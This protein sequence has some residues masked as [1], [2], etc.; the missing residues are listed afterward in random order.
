MT[1]KRIQFNNVIQ[2][3]LPSYVREEFP[4]VAEFLKQ[5]YF[6]QEFQGSAADLVQ[7]VD[8]YLKLDNI[9]SNT[10]STALSVDI[11]FFDETISVVSTVGFPDSYGLLQVDDEVI[12]YTNKTST[13]FTGC[14]RGFSGVTSYNDQ[15]KPDELV[16]KSTE[17]A[18]HKKDTKVINLSSL[19]LKEFF[20][21][22]KYQ[23]TPGFENREFY[24]G[25]DKY[26]FLKQSKD[27]YST[28]GT[29]LSFKILFKVL[30]GED[31]KIIKPQDYLS[32]PSDSQ[33]EITNDLV[34]ESITGD[35]YELERSTLRQDSYDNIP[36]GYASISRV[37]KIFTKSDKTYYKLSFDAGYNRD[38]GVDGSLYGNFSI[39]PKT[40]IIGGILS[41]ENT[42]D[43]DSTV[44]FPLQGNLSVTYNDGTSGVVSYTSKSLNQFFGC[45][46]ITKPI[47][48]GTDIWLDV[49]AYGLSNKNTNT[50]IKVRI[51]SV[52]NN[53][54]IADDAY[55]YSAGDTGIIKTLGVN[56]QDEIVSNNWIFNISSGV[57]VLSLSLVDNTA[58]TYRLTTKISHNLKV[59]DS[60]KLLSNDGTSAISSVTNV[61]SASVIEVSGQ[62]ILDLTRLYS[63]QRNLL[64]VNSQKYSNL[65]NQITDVQN[66]YKIEDKTLVASSSLPSYNNQPLN[67]FDRSVVFSGTFSGDTFTITSGE[68]HGFYTGDSVYYTP[69]QGSLFVEGLYFIKR[70]NQSSVKI[71]KSRANIYNSIFINLPDSITVSNSKFE[72]YEFYSKK[73]E[74]QKI[75]REIN[76]P[77]NDGKEYQT[78]PGPVGILINGVEVLNYKSKDKIFYGPIENID[79]VNSGS[80][81]DIINPPSLVITD[82]VGSGA[83]GYCSV[84]GS[85][86]EIRIIDPGFDYLEVPK[87]NIT[88]GNGIGAKASASMKLIDH[89]VSFNSES[90]SAFVSVS[91]NTIG[92][93]TF[94]KFRSAEKVVYRTNA[95]KAVGGITTNSTYYVSVQDSYTIKLHKTFSDSLV[96]VNTIALTS[97]GIGNHAL[98]AYNKKSVIS[99]INIESA[100]SD[101]Q[102][103]KRTTT[104][105]GISTSLGNITIKNHDYQSGEIV[106]YST[107]G[108]V[109][110][111]LS[112]NTNYYVTKVDEDRFKLSTV[113][114][115]TDN[116]DFYYKTQQYIDLTSTGSGIHNFNY[117]QISVEVVGSIGVS[118]IFKAKVQ[119][120][121]RGEITSVHLENNGVGYGSS[122]I[123]NFSRDANVTLNSGSDAQLIPIINAGKIVEV[124]VNNPGKD[125]NSPPNLSILTNGSGI[126]A[127]LTPVLENGQ[128]KSI[129]IVESGA[130]YDQNNISI[131]V[132]SA[133][134][135]ADLKS[136][137]KSWTINHFTRYLSKVTTDDGFV[138]YNPNS[139]YGL[140]YSHLYVPRKLRENVYAKETG[141]KILYGKPDLIK[142]NGVE[143]N[144]TS[145]SPI[146]GWAYDGNPIYGPY[147]FANKDGGLI[148]RMKSG[149]IL[150]Q[151]L[152]R[153]PFSSGFFV[154]DFKYK[155]I[156]DDS[157]LDEYNGRFCI[158]P[159]FPNGTYAYFAT[160]DNTSSNSFG[161]YRLPIFPYIVG[162]KFKSAPNEFNYK[163][164]S[165][166]DDIDLNQTKWSRNTT[167]Y[168]L[169]KNNASYAYLSLPNILD[170]TTDVKYASPGS[171][172]NIGIVTGGLNYK[173][174]DKVLFDEQETGGFGFASRVSRI[175]GKSVNSISV[176]N[177]TINGAEIYSLEG[178]KNLFFI[179]SNSP[180]SLLN[181]DIV[182]I[183]GIN[184]TS[185]LI[186]GSYTIGISTNTLSVSI[187]S[188]I[189]SVTV[190]GIVTYIS[191]SGDLSNVKEND[192][193]RIETEKLKV[194]NVDKDS[195]RIRVL[196]S[197]EGTVGSAHSYTDVLYE[198]PRRFSINVGNTTS[199]GYKLNREIYFDPKESLG[200]GT[201]SGVGIGSTLSFSNPGV[202]V[203]QIFI[204]T[205]TIYIPNHNLETGDSLVYS[206][207][208]GNAISI[209][210]TGAS[211]VLL[212]D[213]STVY[214]AKITND[215]IGISTVKVG[216]GT[217][218][219]FVG[220]ATTTSTMGTLYFTGIGT[221]TY[222]SFKTN[223]PKLTCKVSKN[224]VTVSTA[225]THGL[226]NNDNVFVSV[227]PGLSTT[228]IIKYNDYNRKV[229]A[230]SRSFVSGDIDI[231]SNSIS[232][233]NHNFDNGQKVVYNATS[234]SGGLIN[235]KIYY[236]VVFDSNTVKLSNSY[237]S[238]VG[239]NPEIVDITTASSG[240]LSAVNPPIKVYKDSTV[241][242]DLSDSSLSYLNGS[243]QYSAFEFNF[244]LDSNYTQ[245]FNKSS[246]SKTFEV[247]RSGRIGIDTGASVTLSVTN[248][249]PQKLYYKLDPVYDSTLPLIKEEINVDSSVRANNEIQVVFSGYNGNHRITSIA[250]TSFTYNVEELPESAIYSSSS[251]ISYETT[252]QSAFGPVSKVD[253]TSKGQNYSSLPK[254]SKIVSSI[255]T[256]SIL[257]ASSKS[258][259]KVQKTKL[260][261]IGFDF[262][263]DFTVR[264]NLILPQILKIEP[265]NSIDYIGITSTGRG[266]ISA[267]KLVVL[268]GSTKQLL[269][270]VDIRYSLEDN[271]VTI[272]KNTYR[273]NDTTPTIIPTQNSN[274]VGIGSIFHNLANNNVTVTLSVGFSTLSSF[275]FAVNDKILIENISVGIN[276][277]GKGFNSENYNY[278][279]FTIT[280]VDA[281]IGG[282]GTVTYNLSDHLN[283][284]EVPGRYDPVNS[285]GR[286]IPEKYFPK[287]NVGLKPNN[288]FEN[289][290][291][292]YPNQMTSLGFVE[293]WNERTK[294]VRISSRE[295]IKEGNVLEGVSSKTQGRIFSAIKTEGFIDV[296][297]YSK[298]ENGW[299]TETGVLNNQ[300]QRIQDNFY[301]QNF[302]YSLKSKVPYD[303]WENSVGSLNHTSGFKKFS[304]Y[305][306]ESFG[307]SGISTDAVSL[308]DVTT[309]IDGFASLNCVYDF[310]LARENALNIGS[311]LISDEITFSSRILTDYFESV[312]NRVLSIDDIS[313]QFNSNP[314]TTRFSIVHRFLLTDARAQK[315]VTYVKDR[316][317]TS[318][319]QLMLFTLLHD[320]TVGYLNQ[321]GRVETVYD[322]G[323]FDFIVDGPEG[324][325]LFYPTKY[326]VNDY[327]VTT[328]SYNL[329][330]NFSGVGN[331]ILGNIV[332]LN[333]DTAYV[334]SGSTSIIDIDS[335][336]TS[337]KV[338]IEIS[339]DNGQYQF[340]ELN[341]VHDGTN[342]EMLDYGQ[343]TSHST[344]TFSSSGLGTYYP[345]FSGSNL[346]IDFIP[347]VGIAAS[348]ST[349]QIAIA[350]TSI[351]GVGTF[352]LKYARFEAVTTSIASTTSPSANI[353][354][355]YPDTYDA[356]YYIIQISDTTN[357]RHQLSEVILVDDEYDVYIT[358]FG[359]IET[360]SSLG[361]VGAIKTTNS[362]RLTFTPLPNI[363]AHVKV[364]FNSITNFDENNTSVQ[365]NNNTA[366]TDYSVYYGTERDVK[367]SFDLKHQ[368]NPIFQKYFD[369]SNPS[370]VSVASSVITINNHFFVTGENVTYS[371]GIPTATASPIGIALTYFGVGIGTTDKLP[372]SVY[373][374]KVDEN[375]IKLARS[376]EDALKIVP[377]A[378]NI[379]SVGIGS[380]HVFISTKQN[381]KSLVS[382]DNVI[383]SPIVSTSTTT[384]LSTN[385]LSVEDLVYLDSIKDIIT[386]DL[387][388]INDEIMK[389]DSVGVGSTN[390]IR[391]ARPWLGT[392]V[393]S[394]PAGS[395]I[396][397]L[398]GNY[399]IVKNKINFVEAPY[400]NI[401]L[402]TS[403]NSPSERD[404]AGITSSS[405]FHGRVFMRSGIIDSPNE[406]YYKNYIF[407]DISS[408]FNG[409]RKTF[410]LSS[411][412]SNI[413]DIFQDNAIIL[414]NDI[415]QQPG[416]TKNYNLSESVGVTSISFVGS[417]TSQVSDV[418]TSNLP[419]GG[420]I[421]SVGSTKGFGYQPLVSAGGSAIVSVAGTI[422][423][424]SIGN[425]GSG[426]RSAIETLSGILPVTVRVGVSTYSTGT[427]NVEFIGTATVSNGNIVSIAVTNPGI[428]YTSSNPPYVI[429]DAPLSY[430]DIPLIYNSSSLGI[431]TRATVDI[432]V[433]Q[434][435]GVIDFEIKNTGYR[436]KSGDILTVPVGGTIGIPTTPNSTLQ[437]FQITV[438]SVDK[439]KFSGWSLGELEVLDNIQELFDG[440]RIIFPLLYNGASISVYAKKG[441]LIDV[442]YVLLVFINDILQIPDEGY[443]F[444]GGSKIQF[445]EPPKPEDTCKILFYK[446]SGDNIDVIFRDIIDTVKIG[447]DLQLTYDSFVGQSPSLLE[448][449]RK[450]VD[451]LSIETVET[452]SYFGPGNTSNTSL[453]RPINW[454]RQTEDLIINEKEISKNREFY[455]PLI[456]PSTNIIQSVG[457]GSTI[458]YVENLRPFFNPSNE[459][460]VSLD[461]QN[462]VTLI[463]QDSKISATAS[464][465][466]SISG[467]I[468]SID[469]V[470]GGFG[471]NTAPKVTLQ[472]STGIGLSSSV[473]VSSITSGIVTS[474]SIVGVLT[475]YSISNPPLVLIDPPTADVE[476][477]S[478][479]SYSGDSGIIVGL[480]TTNIGAS[481]QI[482]LDLFIPSNSPNRIAS[483][484]GTATTLSSLSSGDF[485]VVSNSNVG[486]STTSII[487]KRLD[488]SNIGI[489]NE[490]LD[491]IYQVSSA[492]TV[493]TNVVGV[494]TTYIRRIFSPISGIGT[495]NFSSSS[496]NFDSNSYTFDNL[497]VNTL[498]SG[499]ISTSRYFGD[500]SWGKIILK[501]RVKDLEFNYYGNNGV[502]GITT[503][504]L[505][506]R[507]LP[508]KYSNYII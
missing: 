117:P 56:P 465:I 382:I 404:W 394:H 285:S 5:Y 222:H 62:G 259:G 131:I 114:I 196:R 353:I 363:D 253:I 191:V 433:G 350:N 198:H 291:V 486:I 90:K 140:Q 365:Y 279:L 139:K 297:P 349:V 417:A 167:P 33:Y 58:N 108:T 248:N 425:S 355:E 38:I 110:G 106:K 194:L 489:A 412:G 95:Q 252:S 156:N 282:I 124:L 3:Q 192:I 508:L 224:L 326:K 162:N 308:I 432:L 15:N 128:I 201:L 400:G 498:Y 364:F 351:S 8:Q 294:Y 180:H 130:G 344:D 7:N 375:N 368:G 32:K 13:S 227:N 251:R 40:K 336:Y 174:N 274:G 451:V 172:D 78:A 278:Q 304:D 205:R 333:T 184:T 413:T 219:T 286:I 228:F 315:Y 84:N 485:F 238:A 390:V 55:Y 490:F 268:D 346:K 50:T 406:S 293:D 503:S 341:L 4:L 232:I 426:Y 475:G 491:T 392:E 360:H 100:G 189:S 220:I 214:V 125:Y 175:A 343:L 127:V 461:F 334:S 447:D 276:S 277:T 379:T 257:E 147:G 76:S 312:G 371:A 395:S 434:E 299:I 472:S 310:D 2:N 36:K 27:F 34:V 469:I 387:L 372:S 79:I 160:I 149:Y 384:Y 48:N 383:Q 474:I 206:T 256:G 393:I 193:F 337:S 31:V 126:G 163:R 421:V 223:Y 164:S 137:L 327:D 398:K 250:S 107:N 322:L 302:S 495:I 260:N 154:E 323:S 283:P 210:T 507:T 75:L 477:N 506:K 388:R 243:V 35:P 77:I 403:T 39:H 45:Q 468:T 452:N 381:I 209:S 123:I 332:S 145:H 199:Y 264:P 187:P 438:E 289:E 270:E 197:A 146:I 102:N 420:I 73:L 480:G 460:I 266:Y 493:L 255:G 313:G 481:T 449:E 30:Y 47:L 186:G 339:G 361:T 340:N 484:A 431:G 328:L 221:G 61:L 249:L 267:P 245:I 16:F 80:G 216:L 428:G 157:V 317:Y 169:L 141:G 161:G 235:N 203:S 424:I 416:L 305:Q 445:T 284:G 81:Y 473:L 212:L 207:N 441:S 159:D 158:T 298:S 263:C 411:N 320:N 352:D 482:I 505:V 453:S 74:S 281:N 391:V 338:L 51:T 89:Q 6:S 301:Y 476:N 369:G 329:K 494:G 28:R 258:I 275:P 436:Y 43:V 44:G 82:L 225:Q 52:L 41:G 418:N 153:P 136:Q 342:I 435:S 331:T 87:I 410:T 202:G 99:S 419:A 377:K 456:Y 502:I 71:A 83:T 226:T 380:S 316:R 272:L 88:G 397:K 454:C 46:N 92:F 265:L 280:E 152:D 440:G 183:S 335:V 19:F 303:T 402:G 296:G 200:I 122:E 429:I 487:S 240:T 497:G 463:S 176:A 408:E 72:D 439:D 9:K 483:I 444:N 165:N 64:K 479:L 195:S 217:T 354:A 119:P 91:N 170:Q 423:A 101:Y 401:P 314:R 118:S 69:A 67:A 295:V 213:Q 496:I 155:N 173:V 98:E 347:N 138:F 86:Q 386:G 236:V 171:I 247:S 306:L 470:D 501:S 59:G 142:E 188:G 68:D 437:E 466:V 182:S 23:L 237:Y 430:S 488:G 57:E 181:R 450:V 18:D 318:Q 241:I 134:V 96:G 290:E 288:F 462:N 292:K 150:S 443:I 262:S 300:L 385:L 190:T 26:L 374:I 10:E 233:Q 17:S 324:L 21:K 244:Y 231:S 325:I 111:G 144:S 24:S 376:A 185:S 500:F 229:L 407:D 246:L 218:G 105:S 132:S 499:D 378:L 242:F 348:V 204:P 471:Y 464:A 492:E 12:T 504:T 366:T 22:I 29:D 113:G 104:S 389:V 93:S 234:P 422:S 1:E 215:L 427:P 121:F 345:Y 409:S 239:L 65:T 116:Q 307:Y 115:G 54:D 177:N 467:T 309:D 261:N 370:I 211:S 367:L 311:K 396:V 446:G 168:N 254:F 478:V 37:E 133:G 103:K 273:L 97:F 66:V 359:N 405:Y 442:K 151:D 357:N 459:N 70:I 120:I 20:N 415:F 330:D 42:I 63:I 358:E 129:K 14:I 179:Q 135:G 356:G 94:H 287:F 11:S 49:Y 321:Y 148:T 85:L 166:Q 457:I 362:T 458:V 109:I 269:S 53:V 143:V 112:N 178:N 25:L 60:V 271:Y 373:I 414:V 230:N 455:E 448:N 399:N 208:S 319:R